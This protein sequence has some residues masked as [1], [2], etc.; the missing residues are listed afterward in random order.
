MEMLEF[1]QYIKDQEEFFSDV[2]MMRIKLHIHSLVGIDSEAWIG[3]SLN[4]EVISGT[5]F[6]EYRK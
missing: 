5:C 1:K 6:R 2:K 3:F 4:T